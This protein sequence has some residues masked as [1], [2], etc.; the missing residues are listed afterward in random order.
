MC[1]YMS[2]LQETSLFSIAGTLYYTRQDVQIST[3]G[4]ALIIPHSL[5]NTVAL[6]TSPLAIHY[7]AICRYNYICRDMQIATGYVDAVARL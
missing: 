7:N 6:I 1:S 3:V 4:G 5:T 2:A